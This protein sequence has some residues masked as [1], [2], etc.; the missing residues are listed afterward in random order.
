MLFCHNLI[1]K[2]HIFNINQSLK[3][4]LYFINI[5]HI[6][7]FIFRVHACM[8]NENECGELEREVQTSVIQNKIGNLHFHRKKKATV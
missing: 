8:D 1:I 5:C 4:N 2:A 6:I 3:E 7:S